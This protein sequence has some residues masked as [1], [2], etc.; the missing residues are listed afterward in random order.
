MYGTI[1]HKKK[2]DTLVLL[3]KKEGLEKE[4]AIIEQD[5]ERLNNQNVIVDLTR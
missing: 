4:M 3:R 5:L 2:F 1:T